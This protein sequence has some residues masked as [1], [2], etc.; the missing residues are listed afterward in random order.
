MQKQKKASIG[1]AIGNALILISLAVG[2]FGYRLGMNRAQAELAATT[3]THLD[4]LSASI[5]TVLHSLVAALVGFAI[6]L[7]ILICS[8]VALHRSRRDAV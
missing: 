3:S 6:G 1:I 4:T 8:L 5:D 7:I 2:F